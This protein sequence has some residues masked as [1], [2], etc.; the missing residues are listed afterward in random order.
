MTIWNDR[1]QAGSVHADKSIRLLV[2]RRIRT[3]D[4]GG[5]PEK[6]SLGSNS[7]QLHLSFAIKAYP[8]AEAGKWLAPR[9]RTMLAYSTKEFEQKKSHSEIQTYQDQRNRLAKQLRELNA[10]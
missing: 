7:D 3:G 9:S 4:F 6:M 5:I 8:T 2:E 10:V 1:P